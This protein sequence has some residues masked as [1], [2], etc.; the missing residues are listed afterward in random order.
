M[1]IYL[2]QF[3]LIQF[4]LIQFNLIQF[5][6][7]QFNLIYII[8]NLSNNRGYLEKMDIILTNSMCT[9]QCYHSLNLS[10]KYKCLKK[11]VHLLSF[12]KHLYINGS[13]NYFMLLA[14]C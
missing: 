1:L 7:I 14:C 4:N 3:N 10:Q 13:Q 5:Y 11:R 12:F 9:I 6:L 8:Y 2:I